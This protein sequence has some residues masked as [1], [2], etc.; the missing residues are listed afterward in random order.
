MNEF[1]SFASFES[2]ISNP[3]M[4]EGFH[5]QEQ[6][7]ILDSLRTPYCRIVYKN[8]L[9]RIPEQ[10]DLLSV[11]LQEIDRQ[12]L[13]NFRVFEPSSFPNSELSYIELSIPPALIQILQQM[14]SH[15][16]AT[17]A[18]HSISKAKAMNRTGNQLAFV[19]PSIQTPSSDNAYTA[20]GAGIDCF[21]RSLPQMASVME[22]G[23]Q[24][25]C[26][27]ILMSTGMGI[28][29]HITPDY[30]KAIEEDGFDAYGKVFAELITYLVGK[31]ASDDIQLIFQG[32]S[33]GTRN[34][35]HTL[36]Y[37][38]PNL[39]KHLQV[40]FDNPAGL[41]HYKS[42]VLNALKGVQLAA[43]LVLEG[44]IRLIGDETVRGLEAAKKEF[45]REL[46]ERDIVYTDHPYQK[47]I[48][49]KAFI[50]T[51]KHMMDGTSKHVNDVP[52]VIRRGLYDPLNFDVRQMI[53][54]W[55]RRLGNSNDKHYPI[56]SQ[57]ESGILEVFIARSHC[58]PFEKNYTEWG[59][60]LQEITE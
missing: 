39:R 45:N 11:V 51:A 8:A 5:P 47:R 13:A 54:E 15:N 33:M 3:R 17:T 43:G 14:R 18:E 58:L 57:S 55:K 26:K 4:N 60:I 30:L 49:R 25:G 2:T 42:P 41:H 40:I 28:R 48:K 16:S 29:D 12:S 38:P 24:G 31:E 27:V 36:Q 56:S 50:A 46:A 32:V 1:R 37:L 20:Q 44:G 35:V 21:I 7:S 23:Q 52:T 9:A 59:K 22:F 6:S 34:I 53:L 19:F 10:A